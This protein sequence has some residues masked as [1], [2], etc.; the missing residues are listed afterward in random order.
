MKFELNQKK[1]LGVERIFRFKD[2]NTLLVIIK[3][4]KNRKEYLMDLAALDPK[5]RSN[6][7]IAFTPLISFCIFLLI[8]FIFFATPAIDLIPNA[9]HMLLLSVTA[10]LTVV[11]FIFFIIL[12]R[13]EHIFVSRV[14]KA[15]ILY[16]YNGLPNKKEFKNFIQYIKDESQ[17]RF[18]K[19]KLDAEKQR[20]GEMRTIRRVFD[21][22]VLTNSQY[23]KAK[24]TLL[25]LA[26]L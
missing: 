14:S 12:S 3:N 20:A 18:E 1:K 15:P 23:E 11:S 13:R 6:T 25:K 24:A 5:S 9:Y 2:K 22:G 8:S 19:L 4:S 26:D 16:F 7:I 10:T 17:A 21:E